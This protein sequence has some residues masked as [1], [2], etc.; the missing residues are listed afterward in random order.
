LEAIDMVPNL[1]VNVLS[2]TKALKNSAAQLSSQ[3]QLMQLRFTGD[4]YTLTFD[5]IFKAGQGQLLCIEI[6][7]VDEYATMVMLTQAITIYEEFH[8][9][10]GHPNMQVAQEDSR[11]LWIK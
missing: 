9:K 3:G 2:I 1:W 7:P 11:A 5:K 10:L 6:R 4:K 8:E